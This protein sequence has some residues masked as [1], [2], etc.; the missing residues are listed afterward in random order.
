MRACSGA[1]NFSEDRENAKIGEI[2]DTDWKFFNAGTRIQL[3]DS[4]LQ[5]HVRRLA[6]IP[7]HIFAVTN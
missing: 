5:A 3:P 1:S 6:A 4:D 7:Q 2:N